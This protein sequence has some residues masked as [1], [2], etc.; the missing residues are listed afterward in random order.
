MHDLGAVKRV[1]LFKMFQNKTLM[2]STIVENLLV[3][4]SG[5]SLLFQE[6]HAKVL[7]PYFLMLIQKKKALATLQDYHPIL[8]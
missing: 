1:T 7:E 3:H 2:S 6:Y 8:M 4:H 5:A